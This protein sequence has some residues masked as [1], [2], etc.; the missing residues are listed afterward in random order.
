MEIFKD[1]LIRKMKIPVCLSFSKKWVYPNIILIAVRD[2]NVKAIL[3]LETHIFRNKK[4]KL[5]WPKTRW[6]KNIAARA[7]ELQDTVVKKYC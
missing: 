6:F 1:L 2:F 4:I 7:K 5:K 3:W